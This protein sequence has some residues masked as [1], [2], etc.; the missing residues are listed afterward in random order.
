VL[1]GQPESEVLASIAARQTGDTIGVDL[2]PVTLFIDQLAC[3]GNGSYC[4]SNSDCCSGAC[5]ND[6]E[7]CPQ[8]ACV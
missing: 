3:R 6:I 1:D 2:G 7:T 5:C 4:K 8:G